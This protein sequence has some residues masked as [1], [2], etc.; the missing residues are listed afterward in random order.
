MNFTRRITGSGKTAFYSVLV[1]ALT[2]GV[3]LYGGTFSAAQTT[4]PGTNLGAI[5]DGGSGCAPSPG[6]PRDVAFN[7]TGISGP[8]TNVSVAMTFG[9]PA[10]TFA[11]DVV[12]V[13]I[14][15]NGASHT[16]F[17][18]T[19]ATTATA[20]GSASDLA[21]P[22]TFNDAA[23]GANWWTAAV[24][25]P[26]PSGTYR[27]TPSGGAG[28]T[29]PPAPTVMNT[30]FAA[31]PTSNG[32]W[33]LRVTDGCQADTGAISAASLTL[34]GAPAIPAN[35]PVDYDGDGKTDYSVV[36]NTGGGPTGQVTWFA[37]TNGQTEPGCWNFFV[38][39]LASDFFVP[40]DYD[41]DNK[42]DIAVWRPGAATVAAFYIFQSQTNTLR[43]ELFG[44]TG[45][46]PSVVGDYDGDGKADVAVFRN[47][48]NPGDQS[49]WFY[50]TT[51]AGPVTF[52]PWGTTG[53]FPAPGDYD[54]DGKN[55][56]VIQRND[57]G[58]QA[59]FWRRYATGTTDTVNFG[60]PTDLIVPGDYDGD[61][62]T[63]IAVVRG[64]SGNIN[65]FVVPSSTGVVSAAP[66][67]VF[68]TSSTDY[69][70]QGDYDGDGKTDVAIWRPNGD[71]TQNF[72][73]TL[74][75]TA[76]LGRFEWGAT[77]DYP[78]ANFNSH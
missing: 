31:I 32:A 48:V 42:T 15:P 68:G 26:I 56:F 65:W 12:A 39:G 14:A 9:G 49:T 5:P 30:P 51:Q 47:G 4:F 61:G 17:G 13:L 38:W 23:V 6:A 20:F 72:F 29:N 18:R 34:T 1:L 33:T 40:E 16:L 10:H 50:R 74:G 77:G 69:V 75:S 78:V 24:T 55:D 44:Q 21:G 66:Y 36:R 73:Y 28:V 11:G 3:L 22:Y 8:P 53:D 63:D 59:R 35:A 46:D 71:P 57:G 37:C 64:I 2:F 58:G 45:D 76:G 43:A 62:K 41:G 19:G 60:T 52:V 67:A 54:G 7:V 27:T 25:T 70:V